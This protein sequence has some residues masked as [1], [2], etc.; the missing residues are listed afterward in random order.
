MCVNIKLVDA[1]VARASRTAV[2]AARL[3]V[4]I[5]WVFAAPAIG[6]RF[7]APSEKCSKAAVAHLV[8]EESRLISPQHNACL[9]HTEELLFSLELFFFERFEHRVSPLPHV[10][11]I[12]HFLLQP[13]SP[14]VPPLLD[15]FRCVLAQ[16]Q[17]GCQLF[18]VANEPFF[19]ALSF[20]QMVIYVIPHVRQD[21][22]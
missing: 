11:G 15:I 8:P 3:P 16:N 12:V 18:D 9:N 1:A 6:A 5:F 17:V 20:S 2:E 19:A 22:A 4:G 13:L 10:S 21:V 14:L 7:A